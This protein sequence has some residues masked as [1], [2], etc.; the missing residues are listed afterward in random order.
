MSRDL[1]E[2]QRSLYSELDEIFKFSLGTITWTIEGEKEIFYHGVS[3]EGQVQIWIYDDEAECRF[4]EFHRICERA[5]FDS[6]EQLRKYFVKT[7]RAKLA[8]DDG[9]AVK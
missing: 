3:R 7:V 2:F 1:T 8:G 9:A 6:L 4:G 5:D